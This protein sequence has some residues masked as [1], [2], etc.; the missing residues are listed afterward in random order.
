MKQ[1]FYNALGPFVS[2][3]EILQIL[4]VCI[5]PFVVIGKGF[6]FSAVLVFVSW[7]FPYST[8]IFWIWGF[9]VCS[10]GEPDALSI[11]YRICFGVV[12]FPYYLSLVLP[13][14]FKKR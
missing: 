8:I 7:I 5:L 4:I 11:I 13:L 9:V 3:L 2:I 1:R 12:W 10:L 14:V 6:L